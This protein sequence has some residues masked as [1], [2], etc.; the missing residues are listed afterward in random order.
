MLVE[1]WNAQRAQ[2]VAHALMKVLYPQIEKELRNKLSSEAM[3]HVAEVSNISTI[4]IAVYSSFLKCCVSK[5]RKILSTTGY[6]LKKDDTCSNTSFKSDGCPRVM[7]CF[8]S[9]DWLEWVVSSSIIG[10]LQECSWLLCIY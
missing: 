5:M 6:T 9:D 2:A 4:I 1:K 3:D 10:S 7:G 8:Y